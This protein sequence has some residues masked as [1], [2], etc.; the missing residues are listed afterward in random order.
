[1]KLEDIIINE[2]KQLNI[3]KTLYVIECEFYGKEYVDS[4]PQQF[5]CIKQ[6]EYH[7]AIVEVLHDFRKRRY[8]NE[9]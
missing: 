6:I 8:H 3:N 9:K 7:S 5:D 2:Y 1:M 4:H